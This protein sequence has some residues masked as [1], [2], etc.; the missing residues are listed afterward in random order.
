MS[1]YN[2]QQPTAA[3]AVCQLRQGADWE[4]LL[5]LLIIFQHNEESAVCIKVK[6][7]SDTEIERK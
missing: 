3:A 1:T 4:I 2:L 7:N 6:K 5:V